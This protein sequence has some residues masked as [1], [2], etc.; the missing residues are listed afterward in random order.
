MYAPP[1]WSPAWHPYFGSVRYL[2]AR[3]FNAFKSAMRTWGALAEN[4]VY[5]DTAGNIG[6]WL[7][8]AA[9]S[10]RIGMACCPYRVT[11]V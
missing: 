4:Q 10:A 3:D 7:V 9:P 1:G 11:A 5:A 8:G 6:W 2:Q